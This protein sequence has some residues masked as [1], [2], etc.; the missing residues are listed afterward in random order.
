MFRLEAEG[1]ARRFHRQWVFKDINLSLSEGD[2]LLITG[3]NG[4]GKSTLLR[5]LAGQLT[6]TKGTLKMFDGD[7]KIDPENYYRFLSWSGPYMDLYPDL[8]LDETVRMHF[9]FRKPI[10]PMEEIVPVLNL[11]KHRDKPLR[12]YSS[13]MLHRVKVGLAIFSEAKMLLLDEA[14]TNM[15]PENSALVIDWVKTYQQGRILIYA[16]NKPE[17]FV[18]FENRLVMN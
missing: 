8:S 18:H 2:N 7:K 9:R 6:P 17:E 16:G 13:G 14:T 5:I 10:L 11:E 12:N 1:L 4:S 15:D 3:S